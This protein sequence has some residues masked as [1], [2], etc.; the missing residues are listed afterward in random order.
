MWIIVNG[1]QS[2][3][4]DDD[5]VKRILTLY[6]EE[7][8]YER[9]VFKNAFSN[10]Y[11][12][13]KDLINESGKILIPWQLFFLDKKNFNNQIK[14]IETQRKHKVSDKLVAKRR[15]TGEVTSKRIID[16]L[17]RQQNFLND[18]GLFPYNSFCGSLK[19]ILTKRATESILNHF[20]IDR[21]VLWRYKGKG[22]ALGYLINKIESGN[23]NV[24]RGVLTNKLLPTWQVVPS[25]VYRNTSGFAIKDDNIPFVFLP[26]EINPDEVESRQI[27]SLIYLVVVI[28]LD[29]YDYF[30]GKDFKAKVMKATGTGARIHAI[31]AEF[32][33]PTEETEKLRGQKVTILIRD[34]LAERFKVSPLALVTTL[35]MRGIINKSEYEALKPA[36]FIPK[37]RTTPSQSPKVS[38]SVEK[39]CGNKSFTAIN[40]GIKSKSLQ[41]IQAQYLIFG[42]VNKKGYYKYRL[43]LGL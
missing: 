6:P 14:H 12:E 32:L 24:S 31:T 37:K 23:I 21:N 40:A 30:L 20:L 39:F 5:I 27:Y 35:R 16:R 4:I 36:P 34:S 17:I 11:I 29:Q 18:T 3:E 15:G 8:L 2:T 43:E 13:Y 7:K 22:S 41:S 38:T 25:D 1:T 26:S 19:S 28:G 9:A 33:M 10:G 42:S